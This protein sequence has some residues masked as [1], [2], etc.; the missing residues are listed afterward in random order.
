MRGKVA[1]S[2]FLIL[3]WDTWGMAVKSIL[4]EMLAEKYKV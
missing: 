4:N 3:N 1:M 2:D